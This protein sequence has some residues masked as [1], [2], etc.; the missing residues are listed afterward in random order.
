MIDPPNRG[1]S[2]VGNC[3]RPPNLDRPML[4]RQREFVGGDRG[5]NDRTK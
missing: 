3:C 4:R 1:Q 2:K 5:G